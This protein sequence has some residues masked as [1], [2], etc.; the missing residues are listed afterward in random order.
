MT[1]EI[2]SIGNELLSGHTI[3]SNAA[4]ISQS[5]LP[6]G[7]SV[8]KVTLLPDE[9][10]LLKK[11]IEEAMERSAFIITTGGLGPTG[12]DLTRDVVAEIF[13]TSLVRDEAVA[14]DLIQRFGKNLPTLEDQ[15]MVPKRATVIPNPLGTAPGFILEGKATVF[16]LPGVPSQM[17]V[18][19]PAVIAHLEKHHTKSHYV[20]SLYL[21]LLSEQQVDPYLRTLE[22]ENPGIDI[23][24]CPGYGVLSVYVHGS[25]PKKLS[26]IRDQVAKKFEA[27]VFSISSKQIE[28]ALHQWMVKNKKTFAA[29]ESCTGGHL[30]ARLT[31]HP[32]SSDYFLGSV[33]SYSNHLKE[34]AL[35]VFPKTLEEHGAVSKEVV[36]EMVEGAKKLT[37]AD[38]AIATSGIAGPDGGTVDKP[39]GTVWTAISTPEK[40]YTGLIP[41]KGSVQSRALIIEYT[42]T[43]LLA[44][45]YRHLNYNSEPYQ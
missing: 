5:L 34:T 24:I 29:A 42:V 38:Y 23:G 39:V 6:H 40:T 27:H 12:D 32:G 18:M 20:E 25:D 7:F 8:E 45:L 3:N 31:E 33:V 43:Y 35:G 1:L 36:L 16:V 28:V 15:A 14:E 4:T 9:V 44:S 17:E 21:C 37:G 19:L 13:N 10:A 11:G 30:A 22:K 41:I 2:L 26:S